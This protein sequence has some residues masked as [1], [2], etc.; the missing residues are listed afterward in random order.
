M[1]AGDRRLTSYDKSAVGW[2]HLARCRAV[3][4][5]ASKNLSAGEF[6]WTGFDYIGEPDPI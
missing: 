2:G 6:V 1:E 3:D 4:H 5:D